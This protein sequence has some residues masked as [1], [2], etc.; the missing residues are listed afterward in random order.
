MIMHRTLAALVLA[1]LTV[2]SGC[3][4]DT[5]ALD[6]RNQVRA[7]SA[8]LGPAASR[9]GPALDALDTSAALALRTRLEAAGTP[10]LLVINRG[11]GFSDLMTPFGRNGDVETWSSPNQTTISLRGGL[12][13]ASRGFGP[14]LMSSAGPSL[15]QVAAGKGATKRSFY[16]LDGADARLAF[17]FDCTLAAAGPERIVILGKAFDTRKVTESCA[18]PLGSFINVYWFD[19]RLKMRQSVQVVTLGMP[20]LMLQR[21]ID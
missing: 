12:L 9:V 6:L 19:N 14:D 18:H 20:S 1:S 13:V 10:T 16:Y 15:A 5:S 21:I 4:S 11:Q 3:G 17:D 2:L 8:V 7:F